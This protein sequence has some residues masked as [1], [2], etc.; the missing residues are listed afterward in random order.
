MTKIW[1]SGITL[2]NW[3]GPETVDQL[4]YEAAA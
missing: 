3:A 1:H 2:G 4:A